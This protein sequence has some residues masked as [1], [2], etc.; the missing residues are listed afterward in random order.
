[1]LVS[2]LQH[3]TEAL[4]TFHLAQDFSSDSSVDLL[5][6]VEF[7]ESALPRLYL[8]TMAAA[9]SLE[10]WSQERGLGTVLFDGPAGLLQDLAAGYGA[11]RSPLKGIFLRVFG[12][13]T[14]APYLYNIAVEEAANFLATCFL[15]SLK[16]WIK[17]GQQGDPTRIDERLQQRAEMVDLVLMPIK[18]LADLPGTNQ[19]MGE[20]VC[21]RIVESIVGSED[22]LCQ[23]VLFNGL[24][25]VI[26]PSTALPCL[27]DGLQNFNNTVDI[28][29]SLTIL[30]EKTLSDPAIDLNLAWDTVAPVLTRLRI[31]SNVI[32]IASQFLVRLTKDVNPI[33]TEKIF[34]A[35]DD[36]VT[37]KS[38]EAWQNLLV[39]VSK[40]FEGGLL[41]SRAFVRCV[42]RNATVD[43]K[44][45][46]ELI[47]RTIKDEVMDYGSLVL[48]VNSVFCRDTIEKHERDFLH[49]VAP[50]KTVPDGLIAALLEDAK[51]NPGQHLAILYFGGVNEVYMDGLK[52]FV[53]L[54]KQQKTFDLYDSDLVEIFGAD[55]GPSKLVRMLLAQ[56]AKDDSQLYSTFSQ[57]ILLVEKEFN[58]SSAEHKA[59]C[60]ILEKLLAVSKQLRSQDLEVLLANLVKL[61]QRQ[62]DLEL[63]ADSMLLILQILGKRSLS[64]DLVSEALYKAFN[65]VTSL[66]PTRYDLSLSLLSKS[67]LL[68]KTHCEHL[69]RYAGEMNTYFWGLRDGCPMEHRM[70]Y[71]EL[72]EAWSEAVPQSRLDTITDTAFEENLED[73]QVEEESVAQEEYMPETGLSE[74]SE[75]NEEE[76]VPRALLE[77]LSLDQELTNPYA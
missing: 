23:T 60:A 44:T 11:I 70:R 2:S 56:P 61:G 34:N 48:L 6:A 54:R 39:E 12:V 7:C 28:K 72:W 17:F 31:E 77:T 64:G 45:V 57:A 43:P 71:N 53:R 13:S 15:D 33:L 25:E 27:I 38:T 24:L 35:L 36:L 41:E 30:V 32:G 52:E 66:H 4:Q 49:I 14:L 37:D 47:E 1:M 19:V 76:E 51:S 50:L 16:L 62:L 67:T 58:S 26:Q 63:R 9:V 20:V 3:V 73:E 18:V 42:T 69:I 68:F 21:P 29:T 22:D 75:D 40:T 10:G 59:L 65:S 74:I 5:S 55:G 8:F 46:V